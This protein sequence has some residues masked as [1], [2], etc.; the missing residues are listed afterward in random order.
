[1]NAPAHKPRRRAANVTLDATLLA[2]AKA[3]GINVS[4]ACEKGLAAE[5]KSAREAEWLSENMAAIEGW[6]R[7]VAENGIPFEE[8]R[9]F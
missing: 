7:W 4:Q 6:N 3:A 2:E 5:L 9:M 1:M 8:Y